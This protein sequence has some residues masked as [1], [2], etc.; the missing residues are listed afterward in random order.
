MGRLIT[1]YLDQRC[2]NVVQGGAAETTELLK[3]KFDLIFFTGSHSLY[4]HLF[5]LCVF[6]S[7]ILSLYPIAKYLEFEYFVC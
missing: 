5:F 7:L 4:F 2:Y 6:R 3:H 1:R